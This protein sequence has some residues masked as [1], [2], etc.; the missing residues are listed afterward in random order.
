MV[1][2]PKSDIDSLSRTIEKVANLERIEHDRFVN[3]SKE[4]IKEFNLNK[5]YLDWC[6]VLEYLLILMM[7]C[8][9]YG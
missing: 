4:K 7:V 9:Y 3:A 1:L 8:S 2:V 6:K 5:I